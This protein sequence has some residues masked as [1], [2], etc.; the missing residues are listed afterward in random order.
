MTDID[1]ILSIKQTKLKP[2]QGKF[3]VSE[4][5]TNDFFFKRSVVLLAEHNEQGTFGLIVNKPTEYNLSEVTDDFPYFDAKVFIGGPVKTDNV[6]FLH[7]LGD[8]IPH[9]MH[10]F[11]DIYW[12]GDIEVVKDLMLAN[13]LSEENIR[14]FIGYSGWVPNQ[15]ENELK[16]DAWI[17]SNASSK[18]VMDQKADDLWKNV[19]HS[20]GK[21]YNMWTKFPID[22]AMN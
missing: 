9:S 20:L 17:V 19:V 3:L 22:P 11:N 5:F 2:A 8:I 13:K 12:G 10:I 18:I 1:K 15:L 6:Y 4:P 14:F 21:D 16:R 7:T